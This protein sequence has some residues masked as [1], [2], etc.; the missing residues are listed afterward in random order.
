M[1][2]KNTFIW[3]LYFIVSL[4]LSFSIYADTTTEKS[5]IESGNEARTVENNEKNLGN[6]N[7]E[8]SNKSR[9]FGANLFTGKYAQASFSGF[10]PNYV[11]S[12]GDSIIIRIWGAFNHEDKYVVDAQGNIFLPNI[13]PIKV[14][15]ITSGN[16]NKSVEAAAKKVFENNVFTYANL[17]TAQPVKVFVTGAV[18]HPGLYSGLSSDSILSYLDKANGIDLERGSFIDITVLRN[19]IVHT[20]FN[21]YDFLSEGHIKLIQLTD[22]DVIFV[23]ARKNTVFVTG[24]VA[25]EAEFEFKDKI[26]ASSIIKLSQP[27]P[28]ATNFTVA[29]KTGKLRQAFHYNLSEAPKVML[30]AGDEVTVT[31]EKGAESILVKVEQPNAENRSF[32]LPYSSSLADVLSQIEPGFMAQMDAIQIFRKSIAMRQKEAIQTSLAKLEALAYTS[33]SS[34]GEEANIRSKEAELISKFV[35]R[36]KNVEPKGQIVLEENHN[37]K[38]ITLEDGDVILIPK[39]NHLVLVQGEVNFPTALIY[40]PGNRAKDYIK[41]VGGYS[42]NADKNKVLIIRRSG[43]ILDSPSAGSN[44]KPG[45]EI[46]VLPK[47]N[48]KNLEVVRAITQIIYQIAVSSKIVL[49]L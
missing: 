33:V 9:I 34:T 1:K 7:R 39:K 3:I 19:N 47:I 48:S 8:L 44:I 49:G 29:R 12:V 41:K 38:D 5:L 31:S 40:K 6:S 14:L 24:A 16:L 46:I 18:Y 21:L 37:P 45:D 26:A 25:N 43:V 42:L 2:K 20:K 15:G 28:S 27:K 32:A 22:G 30:E 13:G 17:D 10:N 35:E 23:G 4:L 36:A 11:I